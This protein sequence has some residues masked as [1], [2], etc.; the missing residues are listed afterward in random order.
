VR[1]GRDRRLFR[2]PA[3]GSTIFEHAAVGRAYLTAF[4]KYA[5]C[6]VMFRDAERLARCES[7]RGKT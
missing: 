6:S 7:S 3:C 2:C 5:G 1:F 4:L